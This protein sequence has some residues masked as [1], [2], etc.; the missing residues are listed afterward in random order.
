[1]IQFLD[2]KAAYEELSD[3]IT[4]AVNKVVS[5]G[6]YIGGHALTTFEDNF[7]RYSGSDYAIGV[8]NGLD[9]LTL[10]LR[11]G[12]IG[13]GDEVI[14]PS[15]TYIATWLAVSALGALP[16]PVEPDEETYN[17]SI[18]GIAKNIT[19]KT[20]AIIPVH[21]YGHPVDM[22]P[23]E[24]FIRDKDIF[25]LFDG[26][27]AHG[28]KYRGRSIG[29]IGDATAWSFYPG[30]NLGAMGDGGAITTNCAQLATDLRSLRNYGST[31]KYVNEKIGVN[32][33][34]D[35]IQAAILD[36]KLKYLDEWNGRRNDI[37]RIYSDAFN[38][39][40][41]VT[42]ITAEWAEH[43]RHLY[44]IR[45]SHRDKLISYLD[46]RGIQTLIHYPIP[47]HKQ[48]AYVG[49]YKEVGPLPVAEKMAS[50][51]MSL[52]IGPHLSALDVAEITSCIRSFYGKS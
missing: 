40:D 50:E 22:D 35:P 46:K 37:A 17:I 2:L 41:M 6:W 29:G 5:S 7:A 16:V 42:P 1:M 10:S 21:L 13:N 8:A 28:S 14:V 38:D 39:L 4:S 25:L 36:V 49:R 3:E 23:I 34:L 33:R 43:A 15:N 19:S 48:S 32:S 24:N 51:V 20:K 31:K 11:A 45:V 44:V 18:E 52:P 30:K 12:G 9:A 47:S 27:Q 26:A